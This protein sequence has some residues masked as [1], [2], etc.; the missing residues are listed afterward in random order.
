MSTWDR[1]RVSFLPCFVGRPLP[2]AYLRSGREKEMPPPLRRLWPA[3]RSW[4]YS[5]VARIAVLRFSNQSYAH[6]FR[7]ARFS[8]ARASGQHYALCYYIYRRPPH[9]C[10]TFR[11]SRRVEPYV[12]SVCNF[13]RTRQNIITVCL[14]AK[15]TERCAWT[16]NSFIILYAVRER[17]ILEGKQFFSLKA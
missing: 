17:I 3:G 13:L 5:T 16:Q 7:H 11:S 15:P 14:H 2:S 6:V 12:D 10:C 9:N 4:W 1:S 8:R